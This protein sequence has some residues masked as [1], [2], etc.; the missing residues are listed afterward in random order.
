MLLPGSWPCFCFGVLLAAKLIVG[1]AISG[2]MSIAL[3]LAI[4]LSR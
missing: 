2:A 1:L 3:K 4:S